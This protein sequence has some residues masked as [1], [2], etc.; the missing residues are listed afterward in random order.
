MTN[1]S[2]LTS[3]VL[4]PSC[5]GA[6][7]AAASLVEAEMRAVEERLAERLGGPGGGRP[8]S[9]ADLLGAGAKR[10]PPL[11]SVLAARAT[12]VPRDHAVAVGCPAELIHTATLYH[13][14]VV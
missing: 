1:I 4:T 9:G 8:Q 12:G 7:G 14:D 2:A 6:V 10:L 5:F 13:D 11:L 3:A